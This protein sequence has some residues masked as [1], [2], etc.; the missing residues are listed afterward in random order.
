METYQSQIMIETY[1]GHMFL[2]DSNIVFNYWNNDCRYVSEL[3]R[4][5]LHEHNTRHLCPQYEDLM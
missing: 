4:T 5:N 2:K 1:G 3:Y